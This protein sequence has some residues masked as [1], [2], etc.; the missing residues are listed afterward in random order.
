MKRVFAVV[1]INENNE[2]LFTNECKNTKEV[3]NVIR[4]L[5]NRYIYK[6]VKN[7]KLVKKLTSK[8]A[9]EVINNNL[10]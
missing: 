7:N 6:V 4:A 9:L 3:K 5:N 8:R 10:F 2:E 1:V